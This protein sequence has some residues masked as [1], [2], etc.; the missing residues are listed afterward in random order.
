[1]RA[2]GRGDVS[3]THI[4]WTVGKGSNVAAPA[5][6]EGRLY[7]VH[8]KQGTFICLDAKTGD[9]I[10]EERVEPR[11]GIVYSSVT[12]ADGKIYAVSQHDGTFV[13]DA[14]TAFKQLAQNKFDDDHRANAC[15][16]VDRNQLLLR[17]DGNLYCLGLK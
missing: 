13:F 6:H 1:M 8:E 15:L 17:D 2:G 14:G 9:I 7:W 5:Y 12:V 11:P 4:L 10:F 3:D 16:A